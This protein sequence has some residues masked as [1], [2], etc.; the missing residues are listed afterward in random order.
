MFLLPLVGALRVLTAT[1]DDWCFCD[2]K[3]CVWL[4]HRPNTYVCS[5]VDFPVHSV[6][7][8]LAHCMHASP[9]ALASEREFIVALFGDSEHTNGHA[10]DDLTGEKRKAL[11]CLLEC[12]HKG[13]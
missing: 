9:Q 1:L 7:L 13:S 2:N 3:R 11:V 8:S 10:P 6:H 12:R 5:A 4:A